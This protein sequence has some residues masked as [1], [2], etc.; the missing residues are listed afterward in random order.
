[1]ATK[2]ELTATVGML[3]TEM[4]TREAKHSQ[5]VQLV[6]N[7]VLQKQVNIKDKRSEQRT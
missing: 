3:R 2:E 5:P 6:E 7:E 4:Q 1:M